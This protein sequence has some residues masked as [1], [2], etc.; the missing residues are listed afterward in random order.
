M[1]RMRAT[2]LPEDLY[3]AHLKGVHELLFTPAEEPV[4]PM[5]EAVALDLGVR[6]IIIQAA[7][8]TSELNVTLGALRA[9]SPDHRLRDA[10]ADAHFRAFVGQ[11]LKNWWVAEND[12]GYTD[13]FLVGFGTS[14]GL[15]FVAI[16]NVVSVLTVSGELL[17]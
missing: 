7:T 15:L 3:G 16:N 8:D 6:S 13:L 2:D 10:S 14:Q 11:S 9:E 17:A 4:P 5:R 1:L 12:R